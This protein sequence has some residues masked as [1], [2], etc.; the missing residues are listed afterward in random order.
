MPELQ[1]TRTYTLMK[2]YEIVKKQ[3]LRLFKNDLFVPKYFLILG[4]PITDEANIGAGLDICDVMKRTVDY[5][6]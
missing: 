2:R 5:E 3:E 4:L 6:H 1:G